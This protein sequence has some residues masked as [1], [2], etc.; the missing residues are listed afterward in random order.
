MAKGE[1]SIFSPPGKNLLAGEKG[2]EYEPKKDSGQITFISDITNQSE[3]VDILNI[4][5]RKQ[6]TENGVFTWH[7]GK[8]C[9]CPNSRPG[10]ANTVP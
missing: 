3:Q 1:S 7:T 9:V 5:Y 8:T 2:V 6:K 4:F 10:A